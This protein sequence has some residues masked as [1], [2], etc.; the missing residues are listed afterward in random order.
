MDMSTLRVTLRFEGLFVQ[1]LVCC[2]DFSSV[3]HWPETGFVVELV[4]QVGLKEETSI[5]EYSGLKS[6]CSIKS[7]LKFDM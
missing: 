1:G 4:E 7:N 5:L 3:T 6:I 2:D